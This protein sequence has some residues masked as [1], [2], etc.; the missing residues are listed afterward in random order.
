MQ[1]LYSPSVGPARGIA[2]ETKY[3]ISPEMAAC[4]EVFNS[5]VVPILTEREAQ[6]KAAGASGKAPASAP[7]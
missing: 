6:L 5:R 2:C 4:M 7:R 3:L 1:T